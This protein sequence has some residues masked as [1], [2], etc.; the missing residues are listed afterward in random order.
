MMYDI[1]LSR[2]LNCYHPISLQRAPT[3]NDMKN[4]M[5]VYIFMGNIQIF[6]D[7]LQIFEENL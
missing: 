7:Y 6:E 3:Y 2:V 5:Y 4:D 1:I